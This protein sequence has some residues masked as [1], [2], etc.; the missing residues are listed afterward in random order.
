[1]DKEKLL[2]IIKQGENENTEFKTTFNRE[3]IE[4][5]VAFANKNGGCVYIGVSKIN[6]IVGVNINSESVQNWINEIKS[7]TTPALIPD[8]D[9]MSIDNKTLVRLRVSEYPI[10]PVSTQGKYYK[11]VHNS[12]HL[13][14][15]D[16]IANEHL[17]TI[18]TSWDYYPS[19]NH[20]IADIELVKVK[21]F[22]AQIER[23][24]ETKIALK[25]VDFLK[26]LEIIRKDQLTLGAYLLFA[27]DYCLMSD[28]QIGRF[29]SEITI[30]DS[31]S[32]NTDLFTEVNEIIAFIRKH[33]MVEYIITGEPQHTERFDYPVDAIR[34][35]VIN[36]IVHRDYRSSSASI[37]KIFDNRIEFFNPGGLYDGLTL[38][39]LLSDNYTS[40]TRNKLIAKAFKEV[41]LIERYGSGIK[42]II[43]ICNNYGII[44]PKFEELHS[45]F[46]V[47]IFKEKIN[48][49]LNDTDDLVN[50]PDDPV[51]DTN[52]PVNDRI[53]KIL[54]CI[55]KN[56]N[57][58]RAEIADKC[59]VSI[60]TIKRDIQNLKKQNKLKRVGSD[61]TGYWQ[62]IK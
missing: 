13:L 25:P 55:K 17:K 42:R 57:I 51:N 53:K 5:V 32:L 7:K 41:G 36:M 62:I 24:T 1:M 45:G 59:D 30:I 35:I 11:R 60:E 28:V 56:K 31:I 49:P 34:E 3:V 9:I 33:L 26:K 8:L 4:T 12:N 58:T 19:P 20:T 29:K 37:I 47:I 23:K 50:D 44:S 52:D 27:K 48:D 54:N 18:N 22:I 2:H 43:D 10:K 21:N 40:K 6:N 39:D 15:T 46:M 16:E 61:K 14:S 38:T